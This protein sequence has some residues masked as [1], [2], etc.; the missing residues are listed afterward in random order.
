MNISFLIGNL[1]RDPEEIKVENNTLCKINIAVNENYTNRDGERPVQFFN[2]S[3]WGKLAENCLKY[4]KK[5]S[6]VGVVGKIQIRQW[7][8]ENNVKRSAIEVIA[9]EIE[10]L[11]SGKKEEKVEMQEIKDEM[12][13]L[14]F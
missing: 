9:N 3:V 4:L 1:S 7:E 6:K 10:F 14:P 2:V 5:G 13:N 12:D 8:D 11:S